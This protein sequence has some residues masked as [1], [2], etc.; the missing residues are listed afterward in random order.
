M[1]SHVSRASNFYL[2]SKIRNA[3][4]CQTYTKVK[5]ATPAPGSSMVLVPK[6]LKFQKSDTTIL[7]AVK[8]KMLWLS[9]LI[10]LFLETTL[11]LCPPPCH[12]H[13]RPHEPLQPT[14]SRHTPKA[15]P[16]TMWSTVVA[17]ALFSA[18]AFPLPAHATLTNGDLEVLESIVSKTVRASEE[19]TAA[20]LEDMQRKQDSHFQQIDLRFQPMDL[21]S[22][23][24]DNTFQN[25]DNRLRKPVKFRLSL[26]IIA[27]VISALVCA[28]TL[29]IGDRQLDATI[30]SFTYGKDNIKNEL[31]TR[32][33]AK[34]WQD[35]LAVEGVREL[36]IVALLAVLSD[37]L[38]C[39]TW[40]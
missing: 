35:A 31:E 40:L 26:P 39:N 17:A 9:F 3:I 28:L 34:A 21:P 7:P 36:L 32:T 14:F 19:R 10:V 33:P 13:H 22:K 4:Q 18:T 27:V 6:S 24:V 25:I 30:A 20:K 38:S 11:G 8:I 23:G 29:V 1:R 15:I 12:H 37:L 5:Q 2:H 16:R